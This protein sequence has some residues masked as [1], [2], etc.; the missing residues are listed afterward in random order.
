MR[1]HYDVVIIGGGIQGLS[2]AYYLARDGSQRVVV[3]EKSYLGSG[4]SGRNGEMIRSAFGSRE[5]I[6]LWDKSLQLWENLAAD[7]GFNVMFT[8]HGYLVLATNNGE[9]EGLKQNF[10]H[11]HELGLKTVVLD[12]ED[13]LKLIPVMNPDMVSGG[14]LQTNAG[15]A[16]HDAAIWGYARAARRL[17]VDIYPFTEVTDIV[18][19]SGSVKAVKTSLGAVETRT[20]VNAAGAHDQ[21]VAQMVGLEL[22]TEVHRV[23]I[24]VTEPLKPFL[25]KAVSAPGMLCYM[26]QSARGEFIGGAE[27]H[28]FS[29]S[30]SMKNSLGTTYAIASKY[31]RLFPRL[32]GVRIMRQWTGLTSQTPDHAPIIGPIPEIEGFILSVAWGGYGFMG[33]PGGGK[34]LSEYILGGELSP[35]IRPFNSQRFKTGELIVESAIIKKEHRIK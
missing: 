21:R 5:W 29:P 3:F 22:P 14:L 25:P 7:V 10:K 9:L 8:R 17:N 23:E 18:V 26:H 33:G 2:L 15:F 6:G 35:E 31:V 24:M 4:A 16:R 20:V 28:D 32:A 19:K 12:A 11:Q 34:A 27:K 30:T 13:V 1:K